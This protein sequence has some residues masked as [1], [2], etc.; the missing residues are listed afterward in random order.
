VN[1]AYKNNKLSIYSN[2]IETGYTAEI[3]GD[4]VKPFG[5]GWLD[6]A[7]GA[8]IG[9]IRYLTIIQDHHFTFSEGLLDSVRTDRCPGFYERG[10]DNRMVI[11]T[12]FIIVRI[13][14]IMQD[15]HY[16][17]VSGFRPWLDEV[18]TMRKRL[19]PNV[20]SYCQ[21]I[22]WWTLRTQLSCPL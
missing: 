7:T 18:Y 2:V 13:L 14:S 11:S 6:S 16:D 21:D 9:C 12:I 22:E 8:R 5:A 4:F 1:H 17:H 19:A 10:Y 3:F 20:G 15:A